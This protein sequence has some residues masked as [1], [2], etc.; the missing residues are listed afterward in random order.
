MFRRLTIVALGVFLESAAGSCV[1]IDGGAVEVSWVVHANGRAIT[2]CTC[3]DPEIASVRIDI[4]G[5]GGNIQ[6]STPCAGQPRCV[7]SCQRQTGATPFNIPET[8]GDET[9]LIQL[10]AVDKNGADLPIRAPLTGPISRTVV[11]GQPTELE[12]VTL[13]AG[14]ATACETMNKTGVCARP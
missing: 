13:D 8:H 1:Q 4:V 3:S 6:G 12:A 11:N 10:V 14:C 2:D 5:N 9:Y 7:F